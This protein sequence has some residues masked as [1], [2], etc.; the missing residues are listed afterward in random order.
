MYVVVIPDEDL[1]MV[2]LGRKRDFGS[3]TK[4]HPDDVYNYLDM[5]LAMIES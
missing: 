2:R 3:R 5:A 4:P 1:I